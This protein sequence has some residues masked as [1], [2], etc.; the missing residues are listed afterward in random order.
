[1]SSN[2]SVEEGRRAILRHIHTG[3]RCLITEFT[4]AEFAHVLA[5][6]RD[7]LIEPLHKGAVRLILTES[8]VAWMNLSIER[9]VNAGCDHVWVSEPEYSPT[10][11]RCRRC[12][13]TQEREGRRG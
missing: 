1:M 3:A 5:M 9:A 11:Q 7:S 8:G 4:T 10:H 6:S 12:R 2:M 13:A